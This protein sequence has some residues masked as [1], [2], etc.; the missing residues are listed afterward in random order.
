MADFYPKQWVDSHADERDRTFPHSQ[1]K[2]IPA[3]FRP[4]PPLET[5]LQRLGQTPDPLIP[6]QAIQLQQQLGHRA[7]LLPI[8]AAHP[9]C[10]ATQPAPRP[11][12]P[13]FRG[14][15]YEVMGKTPIQRTA[16]TRGDNL[17]PNQTQTNKTGL[18][19]R[20]KAGIERLSGMPM[21]DIRVHYNS[22]KPAQLQAL[23]YTQGTDIHVATGQTQHLPHEAWHAVQQKQGRVKPTLQ[24]KGIPINDDTT[25]ET[26]ATIM[27]AKALH[28]SISDCP[29]ANPGKT[30][31]VPLWPQAT[32][33]GTNQSAIQRMIVNE[34]TVGTDIWQ[35]L[36]EFDGY[37]WDE[38]D[39]DELSDAKRADLKRILTV[40]GK[41]ALAKEIVP[42]K[43]FSPQDVKLNIPN[44]ETK[45]LDRASSTPYITHQEYK[46][47]SHRKMKQVWEGNEYKQGHKIY[48]GKPEAIKNQLL[49]DPAIKLLFN[50][51]GIFLD[52]IGWQT[53]SQPV[54]EST[55]SKSSN[56]DT[57]E[58][59][60]DL[61]FF[62]E[63]M[64]TIQTTFPNGM[65]HTTLS[66]DSTDDG[67][68]FKIGQVHRHRSMKNNTAPPNFFVRMIA[69]Q[70]QGVSQLG[71]DVVYDSDAI[72]SND[73]WGYNVWPKLGFDASVPD[74]CLVKMQTEPDKK[75]EQAVQWIQNFLNTEE[76]L[77]FT[78]MFL[79][80]D[81]TTYN[82]LKALWKKHGKTVQV[83][84][85]ANKGSKSWQ[86][87]AHYAKSKKIELK[88]D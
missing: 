72:R 36:T 74:E 29:D 23:A 70:A 50:S 14:I 6:T 42:P 37:E 38:I 62:K 32:V 68:T 41:E 11:P 84:F 20:L 86:T 77:H 48:Q 18:P 24:A 82:Q 22:P 2:T 17:V 73:A 46:G 7:T 8:A 4:T 51:P 10:L 83:F 40:K 45:T 13:L 44:V 56:Q 21:D 19:D 31:Q 27:G 12:R 58:I 88:L 85:D 1:R 53:M 67:N 71:N 49:D 47:P 79:V 33:V 66:Y 16:V 30:S 35:L 76:T 54:P 39:T 63:K 43:T 80:E 75:F 57:G 5:V 69:E 78:D 26:E 65:Q 59:T 34:E 55:D 61:A 81:P 9:H 25:L 60:V 15:S 52:V 28:L 3:L 87:L 64:F